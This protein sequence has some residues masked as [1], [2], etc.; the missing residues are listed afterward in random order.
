MRAQATSTGCAEAIAPWRVAWV[1]PMLGR[2]GRLMYMGPLLQALSERVREFS[3]F[4]AEYG[5]DFRE[6]GFPTNVAGKIMR[7]YLPHTKEIGYGRG[8]T[9]ITP[10]IMREL[11]RYAPD[12]MLLSEFSLTTLYG[13]WVAHRRTKSRVV[14]LVEARP[15]GLREMSRRS[16]RS[17]WRSWLARSADAV[18]TNNSD[19]R[20][21]VI[22][23]LG[24]DPGRVIARPYL[25]S[26]VPHPARNTSASL[27]RFSNLRA[28]E[29]VEFLYVGRLGK[30][31]GLQD[32]I[33]AIALLSAD[34][35]M[36]IRFHVVGD[37]EYRAVLESQV[38]SLGLKSIVVF[39]G[40]QPYSALFHYY[41]Q[42]HVFLFP[43]HR[44]YRALAPFEALSAG[45]PIIGSVYD[46]GISET[47]IDGQNGFR[48]DPFNHAALAGTIRTILR[49]PSLLRS[50]AERSLELSKP[51]TVE[52]AVAAI[53]QA[54]RIALA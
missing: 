38:Q 43:T 45:L 10:G 19:G 11:T 22:R 1:A 20:D 12:V 39:H 32:A 16:L 40:G 49:D 5:G 26:E 50:F 18:L 30:H 51:Y 31:K 35:R 52:N 36:R 28:G 27:L 42:A 23:M 33:T 6:I 25:V 46:G 53:L 4:A 37:G 47:V 44:D 29:K 24:V 17:L 2:G 14:L 13:L 48:V 8:F 34:E 7:F 54:C 9:L 41:S 15:S 3:V 21:Y